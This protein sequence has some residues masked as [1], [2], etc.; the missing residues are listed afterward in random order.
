MS[1]LLAAI[2]DSVKALDAER[3]ASERIHALCARQCTRR[4]ILNYVL[5][6]A[7]SQCG[8]R[9]GSILTVDAQS[10]ELVFDLVRG[11]RSRTLMGLRI[12]LGTGIVGWV[13]THGQSVWSPRPNEDARF[14]PKISLDTNVPARSILCV[15]IMQGKD[16]TAVL[17][18]IHSKLNVDFRPWQFEIIKALA[19]LAGRGVQRILEQHQS[20]ERVRRFN[21]LV[22]ISNA[23]NSQRDLSRLLSF[24]ADRATRLMKSEAGSIVLR[25]EATGDLV[26]EATDRKHEKVL[27]MRLASGTGI[28]GAVINSGETMIIED[29]KKDCRSCKKVDSKTGFTTRSALCVAIKSGKRIIGALEVLN[30]IVAE[31][32]SMEDLKIFEALADLSAI[33]IENARLYAAL[34]EKIATL[35]NR[36]RELQEARAQ[37]MKSEKLAIV[38][39]MAAG[40][41]HEIRNLI[42]PIQLIVEDPPDPATID[43][44]LV[45]EEYKMI[46]EQISRAVEM[47]SGLLT[48][49]RRGETRPVAVDLN[50][51]VGKCVSLV[52]HRFNKTGVT[53]EVRLDKSIPRVNG[54]SSQLQQVLVNLINNAEASITDKGAITVSTGKEGEDQCCFSVRDTG[55]GIEEENFGKIFDPFF[56]TKQDKTGTG[57]GLSICKNIMNQHGGNITFSSKEGKGT[58]FKAV[59]PCV[60]DEVGRSEV[61]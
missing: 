28:I 2:A 60:K 49:S 57:L 19:V 37:L 54:V 32:F 10:N 33:A 12:S 44:S 47:T 7:L 52:R 9:S 46:A 43:A 55:C 53:L 11:P 56:T 36:N 30:R 51:I 50:E 18:I 29:F 1:E 38:G 17:E 45:A 27:K 41:S 15:P 24:I 4:T 8:C 5:N 42:T 13:A 39:E 59:L 35:E 23:V 61:F 48:F 3:K 16:A 34:N 40:M 22:H 58:V 26:F 20:A 6:E 21:T 14:N 25:D 31:P